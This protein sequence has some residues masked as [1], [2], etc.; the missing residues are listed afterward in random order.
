MEERGTDFT[1]NATRDEHRRRKVT[2]YPAANQLDQKLGAVQIFI[3][4]G[5]TQI[6]AVHSHLIRVAE[7]AVSTGFLRPAPTSLRPKRRLRPTT[8]RFWLCSPASDIL[9]ILTAG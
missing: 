5:K 1:S 8:T 6:P 2:R 9:D 4:D 7:L 3:L